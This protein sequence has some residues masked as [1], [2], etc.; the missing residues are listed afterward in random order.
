MIHIALL[1]TN[2]VKNHML[3]LT[4]N[5]WIKMTT[6]SVNTGIQMCS[7]GKNPQSTVVSLPPLVDD[8]DKR[9][10]VLVCQKTGEHS[11]YYYYDYCC[12]VC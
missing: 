9:K 6:S 5:L 4:M 10:R 11:H 2:C 1:N 3:R 12:A 8:D 7:C